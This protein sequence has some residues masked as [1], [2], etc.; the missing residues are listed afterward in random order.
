MKSQS[1]SER[2]VVSVPWVHPRRP[3]P[4]RYRVHNRHPRPG[5]PPLPPSPLRAR[6][7]AAPR[8]PTSAGHHIAAYCTAGEEAEKKR[9]RQKKGMMQVCNGLAGRLEKWKFEIKSRL[10]SRN[11][12][13]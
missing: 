13:T 10:Y 7:A 2:A 11:A 1:T 9:K 12:G 5:L 4:H 6:R 3:P 8:A